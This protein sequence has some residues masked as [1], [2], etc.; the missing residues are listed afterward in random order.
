MLSNR[1]TGG[2]RI[3]TFGAQRSGKSQ[4]HIQKHSIGV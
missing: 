1:D 4:Q 2:K 3:L